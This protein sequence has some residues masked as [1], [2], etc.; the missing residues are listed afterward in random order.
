[1]RARAFVV[2]MILVGSV[3]GSSFAQQPDALRAAVAR[4]AATTG[5]LAR[6]ACFDEAAKA[7]GLVSTVRSTSPSGSAWEVTEKINPL[8]DSKTVVLTNIAHDGKSRMG[9]PIGLVIRCQSNE[10]TLYI[11]WNDYLGSEARVMSRIG[12]ASA[13][14]QVWSLSTDKKAT[15]YPRNDIDFIKKLFEADTFIAQVT[16]Y[17]ESPVTAIW[18]VSGLGDVIKPLRSACTW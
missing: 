7:S 2:A 16:P 18:N 5:E 11:A 4:C 3:G 6:L 14:T 17:N 8:D 13:D 9:R 15:F 12:G 10:T 1:M